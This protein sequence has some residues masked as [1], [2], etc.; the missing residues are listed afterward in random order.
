MDCR[1]GELSFPLIYVQGHN[2]GA[3]GSP[4]ATEWRG[5]LGVKPT[6]KW[7][8]Q[9]GRGKLGSGDSRVLTHHAL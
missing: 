7:M 6:Q 8:E 9:G 4:L 5:L 2:S 1:R 3:P